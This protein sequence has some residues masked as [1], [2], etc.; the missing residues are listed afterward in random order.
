MFCPQK[1]AASAAPSLQL[2]VFTAL[3]PR[4]LGATV[5]SLRTHK[6]GV[7]PPESLYFYRFFC[8]YLQ[9]LANLVFQ[10]YKLLLCLRQTKTEA[11]NVFHP[12]PSTKNRQ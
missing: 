5:C 6:N 3:P 8:G 7:L 9:D 11:G 10:T 1:K 4:S 2:R 12:L